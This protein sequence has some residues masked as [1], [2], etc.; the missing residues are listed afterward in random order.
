[1]PA[2]T[3]GADI[4]AKKET[5]TP[6]FFSVGEYVNEGTVLA[7]PLCF[8]GQSVP[9]P[10]GETAMTCLCSD[11]AGEVVYCGTCGSKAHVLAALVRTDKGVVTDIGAVPGADRIDAVAADE[12]SVYALASGPD[13]CDLW[14]WPR[15]DKPGCIQ[16]WTI[17]RHKP[18]KLAAVLE[19][20]RI[21]DTVS[22]SNGA[23]LYCLSEPQGELFRLDLNAP[24]PEVL[25]KLNEQGA[26]EF[27]RRIAMDRAGRI[28]FSRG[29]GRLCLR[30]PATGHIEEIGQVPS[31]AGR[32]QH[33]Q[34]SAWV[35][36]EVTGDI[37]GGT[38]PDGYLFRLAPDSAEITPLG[39]PTRL[40]EVNCLTVGCD[41]RIFGTAGPPEDI[42]HLFCYEPARGALR[43]LG[44]PVSTL[45]RRQY[46]YH[47]RCMMTGRDGEI[48][49][50]Q[51]ERVNHL[52][53]YFPP[54][55][56]RPTPACSCC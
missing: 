56:K 8:P 40:D 10:A 3:N 25:T 47:F 46:G 11:P 33:T 20:G 55:P 19:T 39:K 6:S 15:V 38:S 43:D 16:E 44:I 50:G 34:V 49:L 7:V 42:A 1:M 24:K 31:A 13:G 12:E 14:R 26:G 52:W 53:V 37:Y 45:T 28:W 48:Y 51:H 41:G 5:Q 36:D 35:V 2:G 4:M 27:S 22:T 32:A 23:I 17:R 29:P 54:V 30:D 21:A 9:P 18:E